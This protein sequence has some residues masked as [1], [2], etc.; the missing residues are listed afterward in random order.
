MVM[1]V[2]NHL[3][4]ISLIRW[5]TSLEKMP[6]F[7]RAEMNEHI[8]RLGK[9]IS[10]I[11]HHSVPKSL[12][13]VKTFLEDEFLREITAASDDHCCLTGKQLLLYLKVDSLYPKHFLFLAHHSMSKLLTL[14]ALFVLV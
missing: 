14:E 7:S 8:A 6:M 4:S 5:S 12:T 3:S 10:T 2:I 11:Q 1:L 9:S 13:K